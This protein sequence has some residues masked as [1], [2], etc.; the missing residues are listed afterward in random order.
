MEWP[1]CSQVLPIH[2]AARRGDINMLEALIATMKPDAL[3]AALN[4]QTPPYNYTA[5]HWCAACAADDSRG[6]RDSGS[7]ACKTANYEEVARLLIHRGCK[8]EL[9]T[10]RGKTAWDLAEQ[11]G[12]KDL[13]QQVFE[14]S[15]NHAISPLLAGESKLRKARPKVA[16]TYRDDLELD[17]TRLVY[18]DT[19][20]DA[21]TGPSRRGFE[22]WEL[23]GEGGF[24][25]VYRVR[26]VSPAMQVADRIFDSFAV[27]VPKD[28][29]SGL[30]YRN[31]SMDLEQYSLKRTTSSARQRMR[32]MSGS[33]ESKN[34]V[35]ELKGEVEM[36]A[37][38]QHINVVQVRAYQM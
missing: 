11:V 8:T 2:R 24:G 3:K 5:L 33:R 20:W 35:E 17:H 19:F 29:T 23:V 34:G 30:G 9:L 12:A 21:E 1:N 27:K 7:D 15:D 4:I 37:R 28:E 22:S 18:W 32:S 16:D 10:Y 26:N 25:S 38:L 6:R 13:I 36:L 31:S 14:N